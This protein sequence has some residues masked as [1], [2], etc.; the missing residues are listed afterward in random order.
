M[1]RKT[2]PIC[3]FENITSAANW[4]TFKL[5]GPI[6]FL[7]QLRTKTTRE[8]IIQGHK[9][10]FHQLGSHTNKKRNG[11]KKW[12]ITIRVSYYIYFLLPLS[13]TNFVC[14]NTWVNLLYVLPSTGV[15]SF[16]EDEAPLHRRI[17]NGVNSRPNL[18]I[19][20][21]KNVWSQRSESFSWHASSQ[22]VL[23]CTLERGPTD[24]RRI[25]LDGCK[26]PSNIQTTLVVNCL[27]TL[28]A[29]SSATPKFKGKVL[30]FV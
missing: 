21:A 16:R 26:V 29:L 19:A 9:W 12:F 13:T 18:N 22:E 25:S 6:L 17:K 20:Q 10:H 8:D 2:P 5:R 14:I 30:G 24:K 3:H 27:Y 1:T 11:E 28:Y 7:H 15:P 23:C 4:N